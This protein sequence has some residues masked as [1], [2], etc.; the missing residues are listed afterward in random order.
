M[1]SFRFLGVWFT[2]TPNKRFVKKQCKTAYQLF[3]NKLRNKKL[4]SDQFKYLHN[5]VLL[6]KVAYRLKC[7]TL[8]EQECTI[9]IR[10]FNN[11]FKKALNL[12]ISIPNCF[13]RFR[14]ALGIMDL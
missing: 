1:E 3:S 13:I 5:A 9:I 7:T 11:I 6:S 14:H 10:P 12:V 8:T 4:T 2:L